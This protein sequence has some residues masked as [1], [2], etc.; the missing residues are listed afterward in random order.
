M[1]DDNTPIK[2]SPADTTDITTCKLCSGKELHERLDC[3]SME[4]KWYKYTIKVIVTRQN[5]RLV[6]S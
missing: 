1:A 2:S 6:R 4:I 5:E 3:K